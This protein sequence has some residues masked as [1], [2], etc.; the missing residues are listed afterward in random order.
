M[1]T[2]FTVVNSLAGTFTSL[3]FMSFASGWAYHWPGATNPASALHVFIGG[4]SLQVSLHT[5]RLEWRH[6]V[7]V[8]MAAARGRSL[9][10]AT[11]RAGTLQATNLSSCE[12]PVDFEI[13]RRSC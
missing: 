2:L 12:R 6:A 5:D 10:R 11:R 4:G 13:F 9:A 3:T 7:Q 8:A 1:T